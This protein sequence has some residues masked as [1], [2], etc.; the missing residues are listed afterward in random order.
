MKRTRAC[1]AAVYV[2]ILL[3]GGSLLLDTIVQTL[4][5]I[6]RVPPSITQIFS[7][8]L[9]GYTSYRVFLGASDDPRFQ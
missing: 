9:I 4:Q 8:T 6:F 1:I 2:I 3:F 7:A 5:P